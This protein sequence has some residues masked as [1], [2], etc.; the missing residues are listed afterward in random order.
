ML[1]PIVAPFS[2]H[3]QIKRAK[4]F[5]LVELLVTIAIIAI[6]IGLLLPAV[7]AARE[8]ARRMQCGNRMKQMGLAISNYHSAFKQLP[9]AWWLELPPDNAFNGKVWG[10]TILPYI[11]QQALFEQ[12]DHN[13][14]PVDQLSPANVSLMQT[15]LPD[16]ICPSSPGSV[17]SRRYTFSASPIGL[18]LTA[19]DLAP[20]DYSPTTG[21]RGVFGSIAFR[22]YPPGPREG[23][24]QVHGVFGGDFSVQNTYSG[25]LDG[26]SNTFLLGERTGGPDIYSGGRVDPVSTANLLQVNGGGWGDLV[27]GEHWLEGSP[28]GGLTWVGGVKSTGGP[29]AINCTS[30][31]GHGFH[32]FHPGG[33]YFLLADGAV[34]LFTESV[35]PTLLG[36]HITRRNK[37]VIEDF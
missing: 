2:P 13:T 14:L 1:F 18:P 3:P 26:L 9:R 32:S 25:I 5:T 36:S 29:C 8:A 11:E 10:I 28:Q 19:T 6:L 12:Y 23:A 15:G 20:G 21:V 7:Q 33:A 22:A 17:N 31:R 37:E 16:Y 27:G 30:A 34:R 4:G 35:D 24:M